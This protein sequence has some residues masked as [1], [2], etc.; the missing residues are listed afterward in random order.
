M[1]NW[2]VNQLLDMYKDDEK[3]EFVIYALAQEYLKASKFDLSIDYFSRLKS[4]NP[5]YV[6]LYYH[7]AA[8]Y[9]ASEDTKAALSTYEEGIRIATEIQDLHALS[10]LKNAKLNLEMEL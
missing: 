3:D 9:V 4:I 1:D 8:A 6:G 5:N 2:R 7:L 10:E